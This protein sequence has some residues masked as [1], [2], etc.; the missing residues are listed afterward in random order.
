MSGED[1]VYELTIDQPNLPKGEPVQIPGL[2]TFEN[3]YSY[4]ISKD[5]ADAFRTYHT[6]QVPVTNEETGE[7]VGSDLEKGP[8]LLEAAKSMYGV[9]VTSF[10]KSNTDDPNKANAKR[11][12]T[13]SSPDTSVWVASTA[14][15]ESETPTTESTSADKPVE[16][17]PKGTTSTNTKDVKTSDTKNEGGD[18]K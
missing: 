8:T 14:Y 12:V 6:R 9:E 15:E 7:I 3:G 2:G 11:A 1:A 16:S 5:E 13:T 17:K 18:N 4:T 10:D